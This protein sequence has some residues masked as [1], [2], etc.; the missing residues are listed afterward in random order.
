MRLRLQFQHRVDEVEVE[1]EVEVAAAF[2]VAVAFAVDLDFDLPRIEAA[3]KNGSQAGDKRAAL[4]ERSE[5]AALPLTGYRFWE[6]EGQ[7]P[8]GRLFLGYLLFG[9][10][11]RRDR[12]PVRL[13][14]RPRLGHDGAHIASSTANG[15]FGAMPCGYC[16]LR[17]LC[18]LS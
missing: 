12:M 14:G 15:T 17:R 5:F 16:T 2:E 7:P 4:S 10:A 8:C 3:A 11:K 9:E 6:P 13:P 18:T 1:V